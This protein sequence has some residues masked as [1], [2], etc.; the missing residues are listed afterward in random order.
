MFDFITSNELHG[1]RS[2]NQHLYDRRHGDID[3]KRV[4][5]VMYVDDMYLGQVNHF[6]SSGIWYL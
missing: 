2:Y 4:D 1:L 3:R 5:G 6:T